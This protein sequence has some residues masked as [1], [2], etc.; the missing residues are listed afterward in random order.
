MMRVRTDQK[1]QPALHAVPDES[2][3]QHDSL[4][5]YEQAVTALQREQRCLH[6]SKETF[7]WPLPLAYHRAHDLSIE[8][9][10]MD[11]GTYTPQLHLDIEPKGLSPASTIDPTIEARS[12]DDL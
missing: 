6:R 1:S 2:W 11:I 7:E 12:T 10:W 3:L 5:L 8:R 9:L 4:F